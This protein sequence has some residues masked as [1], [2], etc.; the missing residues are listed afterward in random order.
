VNRQS[1]SLLAI[2]SALAA[3][4]QFPDQKTR[5]QKLEIG[6]GKNGR[7]NYPPGPEPFISQDERAASFSKNAPDATKK[8]SRTRLA[9]WG[10]PFGGAR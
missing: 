3:G 9:A 10:Q 1:A 2:A 8:A 5:R 7:K 4:Q 6:R